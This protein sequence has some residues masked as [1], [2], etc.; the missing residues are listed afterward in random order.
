MYRI[1]VLALFIFIAWRWGDW[2]NLNRYY[3]TI[4]Y[5]IICSLLY[6][7]LLDNH[8]LWKHEPVPPLNNILSNHKTIILFNTFTRFPATCFVYLSNYPN[9]KKQYLYIVLWVIIYA[10]IELITLK[11]NGISYHNGWNFSYSILFDIAIFSFLR[12]H[13]LRPTLTWVLSLIFI[14]FIFIAFDIPVQV[15]Y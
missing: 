10:I 7:V 1:I 12:L 13:Y 11:Q 5:F 6:S 8:L 2:K 4:L 3:P 14:I 15:I 9:G